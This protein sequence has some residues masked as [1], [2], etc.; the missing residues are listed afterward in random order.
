MD[1]L[2]PK[3]IY[4]LY[5]Y[6]KGSSTER[7]TKKSKSSS[8]VAEGASKRSKKQDRAPQKAD[9]F[10]DAKGSYDMLLVFPSFDSDYIWFTN[11]FIIVHLI[12]IEESDDYASLD[13][14]SS[15][16]SSESSDESSGKR[17]TLTAF[18]KK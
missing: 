11:S 13:S 8:H 7:K 15:H 14:V 5:Q 4:K 2:D 9:R 16:S 6:V 10:Q 12:V 1:S 3:T 17:L 18:Y